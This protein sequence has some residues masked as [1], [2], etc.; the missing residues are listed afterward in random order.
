M[1]IPG[2]VSKIGILLYPGF[3]PQDVVGPQE[4]FLG[5][6]GKKKLKIS[7][8]GP[9]MKPVSNMVENP[10][11]N[12]MNSSFEIRIV[13]THTYD[14]PPD[15]D[16]LIIPGGTATLDPKSA[17][18]V[19]R[20]ARFIKKTYP[21]LKYL[22]TVCTGAG[23][24]AQSGILDGRRATTNKAVWNQTITMGPKV[25]WVPHARWVV[26]GNIWTTSGVSGTYTYYC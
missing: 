26:D 8:L 1:L 25:K 21:K 22:L 7:W 13:P 16:L 10:D 12:P 17:P 4:A 3:E 9:S 24:A 6:V 20:V 11:F 15:L 23:I 18:A 2:T 14:N 19:D 5:T